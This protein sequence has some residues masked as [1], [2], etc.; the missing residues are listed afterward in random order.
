MA[1]G[2]LTGTVGGMF[3]SLT[4]GLTPGPA[5]L[6]S[7]H[8]TASSGEK[9]FI[10]GGGTARVLYYIGALVLFFMPDVYMRRGGAAINISLFFV[11]ETAEQYFLISGIIAV[12]GAA[13]L[14]F[15]PRYCRFCADNHR[16]DRLPL[17]FP[18]R[19]DVVDRDGRV[20]HRAGRAWC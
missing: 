14:L 17:D 8:A 1:R 20:R 6:M 9:Q 2:T 16:E 5:L 11:P 13:T 10:L 19:D 7:A 18:R 4:P 15:L 12:A 3:S